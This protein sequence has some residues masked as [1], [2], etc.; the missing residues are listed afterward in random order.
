MR[1][2]KKLNAFPFKFKCSIQNIS[3]CYCGWNQVQERSR[4]TRKIV[5]INKEI[6]VGNL[7]S[8]LTVME[9]RGRCDCKTENPTKTFLCKND[10]SLH[11]GYIQYVPKIKQFQFLGNT[12][13]HSI[14][15][16]V[17]AS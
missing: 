3:C 11:L 1:K 13:K 12:M 7:S 10:I 4:E 15:L 8:Y 17:R 5:Y 14:V 9:K 2:A 16:V 6:E